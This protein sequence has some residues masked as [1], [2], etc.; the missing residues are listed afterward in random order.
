[1]VGVKSPEKLYCN[2]ALICWPKAGILNGSSIKL[3]I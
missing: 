3:T 2:Q 1:M